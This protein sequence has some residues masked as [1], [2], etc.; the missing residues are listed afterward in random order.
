MKQ[1]IVAIVVAGCGAP[2]KGTADH[3]VHLEWRVAQAENHVDVTAVVDNRA[4][5]IGPLDTRIG[6]EDTSGPARCALEDT[7][8]TTSDLLCCHSPEYN[9]YRAKLEPGVLTITR[10]SGVDCNPNEQQ[11]PITRLPVHDTVL[12]VTTGT[13]DVSFF[14]APPG[15]C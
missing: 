14:Q 13:S 5:A 9:Y 7:D 2:T 12:V 8:A 4:I 11:T 15:D 10:I 6:D 1:L 3:A